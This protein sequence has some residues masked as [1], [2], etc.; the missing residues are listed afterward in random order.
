MRLKIDICANAKEKSYLRQRAA[1][2]NF[3]EILFLKL[4]SLKAW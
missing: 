2:R 4:L 1:A 3:C